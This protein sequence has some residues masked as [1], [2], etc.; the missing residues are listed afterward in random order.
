MAAWGL[1]VAVGLAVGSIPLFVGLIVVL[2]AL[3]HS[4]WHLYR[5]VVA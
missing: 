4:T 1:V 3:G 5:A 2:P